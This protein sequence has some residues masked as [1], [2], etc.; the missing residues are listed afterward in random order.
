MAALRGEVPDK[1]PFT[2]YENKLPRCTFERELRNRGLCIVRRV[3]SYKLSYPNVKIKTCNYI[4]DQGRYVTHVNYSTPVG[5]LNKISQPAGFTSWTLEHE[6]KTPE[7]YKALLFI[8]KDAVVT[9]NYQAVYKD[10][11]ELGD[12]FVIRDNLPLEP[13][14]NLISHYMGVETFCLEWMENRDEILKLYDAFVELARKIYPVAANGPLEFANYGGNV[15]PS[16]IGPDGFKNYYVP[17]YEEAAEV[18]HKKGKMLG[19]HLDGDNTLIMDLIGQTSLD[20]IEAYDP[21]ISPPLICA[22]EKWP[23]KVLWINWP[24]A[25]H[26]LG[27]EQIFDNTVRLIEEARTRDGFLIGITEDVPN[28]RW[29]GNFLKIMD[30]IDATL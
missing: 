4:D 3:A 26:L 15:I 20:Y 16:V 14:Q 21:G 22:R 23:D 11:E 2:A 24:S 12:D 27:E 8:I 30:A 29:K 18:F 17:N 19:C 9:E 5:E 25:W 6:F 1:I 10:L 28:D 13:L 7:D